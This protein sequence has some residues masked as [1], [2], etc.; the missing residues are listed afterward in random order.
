MILSLQKNVDRSFK[1]FFLLM[2]TRYIVD[3]SMLSHI[4]ELL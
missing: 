1:Y 2:P 4:Y 3:I